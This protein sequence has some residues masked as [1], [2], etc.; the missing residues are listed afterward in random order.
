MRLFRII[1]NSLIIACIIGLINLGCSKKDTYEE[2]KSNIILPSQNQEVREGEII[3]F[4]GAASGGTPP[5][6]YKW[7]FGEIFSPSSKK[8]PGKMAF[9]YEG[10][11][12][13][14]F[15]VKDSKGITDIDFVYI[16]VQSKEV[17]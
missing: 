14:L 13:I 17:L 6:T 1:Y 11:Y 8:T 12:K 15:T 16:F 4:E 3:Y 5:Y 7:N 10:A 9:N 2:L